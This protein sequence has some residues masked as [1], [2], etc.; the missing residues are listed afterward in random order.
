MKFLRYCLTCLTPLLALAI[1]PAQATEGVFEYTP[2]D[3]HILAS[4]TERA[5]VSINFLPGTAFVAWIVTR[6]G[7]SQ[8]VHDYGT[9]AVGGHWQV[10]LPVNSRIKVGIQGFGPKHCRYF[11]VVK[12]TP[13]T[14]KFW[15]ASDH[16]K[17][18]IEG[19]AVKYDTEETTF[20]G[21]S[22]P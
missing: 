21:C 15:G 3:E 8:K 4:T 6:D 5:D 20:Q 7:E 22:D 10:S 14:I 17:Y 18:G 2:T 16:S 12:R 19:D 9:Y 11:S 1:S 13:G